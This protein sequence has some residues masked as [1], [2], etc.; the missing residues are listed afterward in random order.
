MS[1]RVMPNRSTEPFIARAALRMPARGRPFVPQPFGGGFESTAM[2]KALQIQRIAGEIATDH[3]NAAIA[4]DDRNPCDGTSLYIAFM[5]HN[6]T[7]RG[8][9]VEVCV[10]LEDVRDAIRRYDEGGL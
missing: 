3:A 9:A 4:V 6:R 7:G 2:T 10:P 5:P 1:D 8:Q